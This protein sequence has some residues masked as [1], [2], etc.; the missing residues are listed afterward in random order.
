M[1]HLAHSAGPNGLPSMRLANQ[2]L[3]FLGRCG[4]FRTDMERAG[5]NMRC[6]GSGVELFLWRPSVL[7]PFQAV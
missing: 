2:I 6:H 3:I 4:A 7:A 1:P 5:V